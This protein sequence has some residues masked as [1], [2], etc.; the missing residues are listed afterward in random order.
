MLYMIDRSVMR[1][2]QLRL[3]GVSALMLQFLS[4][5]LYVTVSLPSVTVGL[6]TVFMKAF[7]IEVTD[8]HEECV[9][10]CVVRCCMLTL[11]CHV[12]T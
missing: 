12:I 6:Y 3:R 7:Y 8:A 11:Y 1:S 5:P 9:F 10:G 4:L 2:D